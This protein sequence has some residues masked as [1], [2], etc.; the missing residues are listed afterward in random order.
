MVMQWQRSSSIT[1]VQRL[2]HH[3]RW[4]FLLLLPI[5]ADDLGGAPASPASTHVHLTADII[6]HFCSGRYK[7]VATTDWP[8]CSR[9][10][11]AS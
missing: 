5:P 6:Q 7:V 11:F 8:R 4:N 3:V 10:T 1:D 2:S 9:K